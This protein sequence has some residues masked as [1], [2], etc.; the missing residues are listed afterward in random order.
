MVS[1]MADSSQLL[2]TVI[3]S[4]HEAL[5][6]YLIFYRQLSKSNCFLL[7]YFKLGLKFGKIFGMLSKNFC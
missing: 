5:I 6:M 7:N 1:T 3:I 2:K 4:Y